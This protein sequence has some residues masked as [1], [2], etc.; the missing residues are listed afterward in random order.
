MTELSNPEI[1]KFKATAQRLKPMLKVGHA[2][3][4]PAFLKTVDEAL[5]SHEL[6]KI[7]F[8]DFKDKRKVLAP[9]LAEKTSS[10]LVTLIG[11]VV[12]LYRKKP[13]KVVTEEVIPD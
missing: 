11:N 4:S 10:H 6:I 2:G 3:L 12:V 1:R 9:E 13:E 5:M 8:D 7:K